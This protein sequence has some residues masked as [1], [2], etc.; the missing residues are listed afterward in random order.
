[1]TYPLKPEMGGGMGNPGVLRFDFELA[2][3]GSGGASLGG[4][5]G[6]SVKS[7]WA[8][9]VPGSSNDNV[10]PGQRKIDISKAVEEPEV[11]GELTVFADAQASANLSGSIKWCNPDKS[12]EYSTL[13]KVA[14]GT[15]AQ[16]GAGWSGTFWDE[17]SSPASHT[18]TQCEGLVTYSAR[19]RTVLLSLRW[20]QSKRDYENVMQHLS[21]EFAVV[22]PWQS[23]QQKVADFLALGE[24][25]QTYGV[26]NIVPNASTVK[27]YPSHYAE[28]LISIYNSLPDSI[29][30][31]G[32]EL[33]ALEEVSPFLMESCTRVFVNDMEMK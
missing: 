27:I 8:K 6:V 18:Q 7:N 4:E 2:L 32:N 16:A 30:V 10:P 25:V 19:K 12:K 21:K 9:G 1:M 26:R 13:A 31:Q 17:V 20:I 28:N 29:E 14:V 22:G 11:T 15:T 3:A 24:E 33:K 5:L 23:N